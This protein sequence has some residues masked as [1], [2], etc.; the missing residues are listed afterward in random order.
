[1]RWT[2]RNIN[3]LSDK[4][5]LKLR[6]LFESLSNSDFPSVREQY[7]SGSESRYQLDSEI[8]E[9]LGFEAKEIKKMLDK[10]YGTIADELERND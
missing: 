1:V 4:E 10:L 6:K 5:I 8:L 3:K 2:G 9:V 7:I